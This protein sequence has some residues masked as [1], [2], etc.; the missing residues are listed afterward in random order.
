MIIMIII[1]IMLVVIKEGMKITF[2]SSL[3]KINA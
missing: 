2:S 3:H 1:I